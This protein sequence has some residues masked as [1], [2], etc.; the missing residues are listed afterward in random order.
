MKEQIVL[1]NVKKEYKTPVRKHGLLP[2]MKQLFKPRYEYVEAVNGISFSVKEG[3]MVGFIGPNGAGK[4]TTLKMLCGLLYPTSGEIMADGFVPYK[5]NRDYLRE[6]ALVIGNKT[7]LSWEITV[8]DSFHIMKEIYQISKNDFKSRLDELTALLDIEGVLDKL[9]RN[10]SL[11]ERA[12]CELA[13]SLLHQ[14]KIM[15]LDEPTLGMDVSIQLKI[16][17]FIKNYCRKN[18]TTVMLTSHYMADITSLCP[19]VILIN[20][21]KLI[22]DDEINKLSKKLAPFK[23]IK[24]NFSGQG[25]VVSEKDIT[26]IAGDGASVIDH[27]ALEYTIRVSNNEVASAASFLLNKLSIADLTIENP[28]I[29]AVIDQIYKDGAVL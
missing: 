1:D 19:R 18:G 6:I 27:Q 22:Y 16:R 9:A 5:R 23:I 2:A 15:F 4:T 3:E 11:G 28:P 17:D 10:L 21:G 20:K 26:D 7:Q 8:M 29:E 14:P 12:K 13:A 24:I 25:K